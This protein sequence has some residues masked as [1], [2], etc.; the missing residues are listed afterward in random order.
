MK[1]LQKYF[2]IENFPFIV[3]TLLALTYSKEYKN[4]VFLFTTFLI[5]QKGT[6]KLR[7]LRGKNVQHVRLSNCGNCY[8]GFQ[9]KFKHK[10]LNFYYLPKNYRY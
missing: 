7:K 1:W 2:Y 6:T 9:I 3:I 8:L 10:Q 5:N 4:L